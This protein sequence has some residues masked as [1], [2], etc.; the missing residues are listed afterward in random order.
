MLPASAFW[1]YLPGLGLEPE[2]NGL[3]S[4]GCTE[5]LGIVRL[6]VEDEMNSYSTVTV[7]AVLKLNSKFESAESGNAA[8]A[9]Q[10]GKRDD[11]GLRMKIQLIMNTRTSITGELPWQRFYQPENCKSSSPPPHSPVRRRL[12][13]IL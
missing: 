1:T 6:E 13:G 3:C 4:V 5:G 9:L 7:C 11:A 8:A 12:L 10:I 2:S